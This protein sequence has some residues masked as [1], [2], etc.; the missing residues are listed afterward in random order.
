M[1]ARLIGAVIAII[2]ALG[3]VLMLLVSKWQR[4]DMVLSVYTLLLALAAVLGFTL[5]AYVLDDPPPALDFNPQ[6]GA[7][8]PSETA[9]DPWSV[10]HE[11]NESRRSPARAYASSQLQHLHTQFPAGQLP[12][13]SLVCKGVS[14]RCRPARL[15]GALSLARHAPCGPRLVRHWQH[16]LRGRAQIL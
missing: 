4:S 15:S 12:L 5:A 10:Q 16:R 13:I 2:G 1:P 6:N 9:A 11:P 7:H 3:G 8:H 14:A